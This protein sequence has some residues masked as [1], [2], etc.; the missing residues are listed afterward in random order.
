M[1]IFNSFFPRIDL[2]ARLCFQIREIYS[3]KIS[4]YKSTYLNIPYV[5]ALYV[6]TMLLQRYF[7]DVIK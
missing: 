5:A 7:F 4:L 3:A 1:S 6:K 2:L